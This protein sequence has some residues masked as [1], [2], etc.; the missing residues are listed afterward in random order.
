M[1][2]ERF[3]I[4]WAFISLVEF[5]G[6][7]RHILFV[8]FFDRPSATLGINIFSWIPSD[9]RTDSRFCS[10]H[11]FIYSTTDFISSEDREIVL[12]EFY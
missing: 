7:N 10:V 4:E 2:E 5:L 8:G 9:I 12:I 6:L 3:F 11:P 1:L